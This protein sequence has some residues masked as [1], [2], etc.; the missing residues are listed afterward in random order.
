MIIDLR[1]DTV[2]RPT[3]G[4]REA[5]ARAEVGD[6]VYGEDPTVNRLEQ[7]VAALLGK[8]AGLL[9]PSGTMANQIGIWLHTRSPGCEALVGHG[10]H[11][12]VYEAGAAAALSGVQLRP[13]G[14]PEGL[15]TAADVE[16]A[17]NPV[18]L[19]YA[20][21]TLVAVEN[22]HNR[23]GGR[24]F[25]QH[26]VEA[27]AAVARSHGLKLHLDGARLWNAHVATGLSLA[28]LAAP[29]DT[30]SVC[31][32]KGLGAPAGSLLCGTREAIELGRRR[33]K[34]LGGGMRQA[35]VL[36]AAGRY[37]I[38]H[39]LSRL[40]ED[41]SNA[42]LLAETLSR[43]PGVRIALDSVQTNIVAWD[44]GPELPFDA[45]GFVESARARGLLLN[46]MAARR[47]RAV[48][49][50][51]VDRAACATAAERV[52]EVLRAA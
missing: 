47:V 25:P 8:P 7:E 1:S 41:H 44:L 18:N 39:H 12:M 42:R 3:P 38:E 10:A 35:G 32:S 31:L 51:D 49:H 43:G 36:A 27:I 16:E 33:R 13:V 46:A 17:V 28:T 45:A 48:T 24:V 23:G 15:F 2:T 20:A 19:H 52:L 50:L 34:M 40:V 22:T 26:D 21:T 37:A 14:S 11:C 6:D 4:M 9:V 5:M 30:V 29:F